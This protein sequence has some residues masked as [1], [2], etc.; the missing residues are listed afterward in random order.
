MRAAEMSKRFSNV[1][2]FGVLLA[3]SFSAAGQ[4]LDWA[5][6]V[7]YRYDAAGNIIGIGTDDY[8]YDDL[9][10]LT[11]SE[12]NG[13]RRAFTYDA[14]G[15]RTDCVHVV[16]ESDCQTFEID[17]ATNRMKA[18]ATYDG[19]GNV[20]ALDGHVYRYD[21]LDM[22]A[23][24]RSG[25]IARDHIYTADDE[26]LA[27][28]TVNT[29]VWRWTVRDDGGRVL[30]E[31]TSIDPSASGAARWTWLR[32]YAYRDGRLLASWQLE[33]GAAEPVI[34]HY[35]LDHLGTPRVVTDAG[36]RVVG[37]HSYH[38]FGPE[39][40]D[41]QL[42]EPAASR[43]RYTGQERYLELDYMHARY[44]SPGM[45]R[46]LSPDPIL[47][48]LLTPQ[49]WNRYAY[50]LNNPTNLVDPYGLAA[51]SSGQR[52]EPGDTCDGEVIEGWC[53]DGVDITVSGT[54]PKVPTVRGSMWSLI[55]LL[56]WGTGNL[57]RVSAADAN[58]A[59]DLSNTPVMDQIR[60]E[61]KDQ[62]CEDGRFYGD[63]QYGELATTPPFSTGQMVGSFGADIRG[64]GHG[65]V[66]V[67][68]FNTWGLES[69]TR[70]PGTTNRKNASV[71]QMLGGA[72]L[73]YPKS[74]LENRTSGPMATATLNYIWIE[75]SPCG[76]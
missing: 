45:G 56:N 20:V 74:L 15:N 54:V 39:L 47:G 71:Q 11:D 41:G 1:I 66:V 6:G 17:S 28:Y 9:N 46:F 50:V 4:T 19:A 10:R 69:A 57:P 51:R 38:P 18:P 29:G 55:D 70:F 2:A 52:M 58:S 12:T 25:V 60:N 63:F 65:L 5:A 48:S 67:K 43:L 73:Q 76:Q 61:F 27:T 37:R 35:R 31:F 59:R 36:N 22:Q 16:P 40:S 13:S 8:R 44:Y 49:S 62:G 3:V 53:T 21:A 75:G 72:A 30:R 68:A 33:P 26:R 34:Y 64:I 42:T 14:F 24:D 7:S 32:D 23:S